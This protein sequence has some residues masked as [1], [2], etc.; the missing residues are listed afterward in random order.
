M[1]RGLDIA[2]KGYGSEGGAVKAPPARAFPTGTPERSG[3]NDVPSRSPAPT[4]SSSGSCG[5]TPAGG[6]RLA[7]DVE[8]RQD[9]IEPLRQP[10]VAVAE[11]LHRGRHEEHADHGGVDQ[12]R[13][14]QPEAEQ[15]DGPLVT[16]HEAGEHAH[17]D[18]G[19][20]RD[21]PGGRG[22]AV[23]HGGGVVV[24]AV[25]LL[26][27]AGEEEDLVVHREAED[28]GEQHHRRPRLDRPARPRPIR[29]PPQ[30]HWNTATT[31][32]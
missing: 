10:P 5:G 26:P 4:S 2:G 25:V 20:G 23:G 9:P 12:D 14:G 15:L 22:Q 16:E 1:T 19:G 17:H 13:D 28:D 3:S 24:R 21:D 30:P 31:T 32:P 18:Q 27:H 29:L 6:V 11:Q 8:L 7:V